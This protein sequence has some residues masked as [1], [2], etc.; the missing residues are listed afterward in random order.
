MQKGPLLW[1][2]QTMSRHGGARM[3]KTSF[4][5]TSL[6]NYQHSCRCSCL[7]L[8]WETTHPMAQLVDTQVFLRRKV[9][10]TADP[11]VISRLMGTPQSQRSWHCLLRPS[12]CLSTNRPALRNIL[13]PA[14]QHLWKILAVPIEMLSLDHSGVPQEPTG[15]CKCRWSRPRWAKEA[16]LK[17]A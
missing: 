12:E 10:L 16:F 9:N 1:K 11:M 7:R 13:L 5:W 2:Y 8:G 3:H 14:K 4:P 15:R 6:H 17:A